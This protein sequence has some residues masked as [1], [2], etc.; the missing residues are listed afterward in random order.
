MV[1][2][3]DNYITRF[4]F[5]SQLHTLNNRRDT[6]MIRNSP[7]RIEFSPNKRYTFDLTFL[8]L[9]YPLN[10]PFFIDRVTVSNDAIVWESW[11]QIFQI[12]SSLVYLERKFIIIDW[13]DEWENSFNFTTPRLRRISRLE[14]LDF[15]QNQFLSPDILIILSLSSRSKWKIGV[16]SAFHPRR[17]GGDAVI[18]ARR[19]AFA[20]PRSSTREKWP[21]LSTHESARGKRS[22][23][24]D[25]VLGEN[26]PSSSSRPANQ[27]ALTRFRWVPGAR[28]LVSQTEW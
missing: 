7:S 10:L 2:L 6:G 28:M 19:L 12:V 26:R 17:G 27:K 18:D 16:H 20:R 23:G 9:M 4:F 24:D 25:R 21:C 1:K 8:E 13:N 5:G 15:V 22:K 14:I 3:D 11:G